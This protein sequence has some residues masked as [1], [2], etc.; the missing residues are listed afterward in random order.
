VT[1]SRREAAAAV[2]I[3][4]ALLGAVVCVR[5]AGRW[6]SASHPDAGAAARALGRALPREVRARGARAEDATALVLLADPACGACRAAADDLE[7]E[8]R[9]R[10]LGVVAVVVRPQDPGGERTFAALGRGLL[11]AYFLVDGRARPVAVLRGYRP[12]PV[13]REWLERAVAAAGTGR[14]D[15]PP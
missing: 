8:I 13:V 11:P 5:T 3:G 12:A 9:P 4:A 1:E 6:W 15:E 7:L 10:D 14:R 2:V